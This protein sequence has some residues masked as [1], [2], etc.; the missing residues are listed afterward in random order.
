MEYEYE[1]EV[2]DINSLLF[3][4]S[5]I[6]YFTRERVCPENSIGINDEVFETVFRKIIQR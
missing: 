1:K 2:F 6:Q 3:P 5:L 4:S